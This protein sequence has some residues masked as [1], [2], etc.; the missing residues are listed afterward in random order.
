MINDHTPELNAIL[1]HACGCKG[2]CATDVGGAHCNS[3]N[4]VTSGILQVLLMLRAC[5]SK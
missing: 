5:V 2:E 4:N 1:E 3:I